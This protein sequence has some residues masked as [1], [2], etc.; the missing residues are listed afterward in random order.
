MT[1]G[2]A[3]DGAAGDRPRVVVVGAGI[4]GLTAAFV[5]MRAGAAVTVLEA[6]PRAGGAVR[7]AREEGYVAELGPST[8][9]ATP[10]VVRLIAALGLEGACLAP[11]PPARRR[12]I[13]RGR[14]LVAV[15]GAPP[16]LVASPLLSLAAKLRLL[17]EPLAPRRTAPGDESVA[18]F[19]RR[20]FG[21][22]ALAYVVE[23]VLGGI[24][25]GDP[26]QLSARHVLRAFTDFERAAGS[27]ARGALRAARARRA[28]GGSAPRA[29]VSF[30][31]GLDTLTDALAGALGGALRLNTPVR[32]VRRVRGEWRVTADA[33]GRDGTF[34]A[35]A[36]ILTTPAPAL[37]AL[38][39]PP[40]VSRTLAPVRRVPHAPLA[41]LALGFR[42][43]DVAHPLDGFGVLVPAVERET[44]IG[45]LFNSAVF[46]E[47]APP[48]HHLITCFVGGVGRPELAAAPAPALLEA[49]LRELGA[50]LGVRAAPVFVRHTRWAQAVPQY[51]VGHDAVGTA[52]DDS[53]REHPGLFIAGQ[54]RDGPGLGECVARA[55]R[56]AERAVARRFVEPAIA[57]R[58][59]AAAGA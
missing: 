24:W 21:D 14:Q 25:A 51:V 6:T 35:D 30:R 27:V 5:A 44:I 1:A 29:I 50:L 2:A 40:A 32:A 33:G 17:C 53:E 16:A 59:E 11:L 12:Y 47:R 48:G 55:T 10:A 45:A 13:V 34:A 43:S 7:T 3:H 52:A 19:V 8:L 57:V 36:V 31:Q 15:P 58:C 46:A 28:T 18:A 22:E 20:R 38:D 37:A 41:T 26:S 39:L 56:A 54:F 23:P 42:T 4:T 49:V 9:L